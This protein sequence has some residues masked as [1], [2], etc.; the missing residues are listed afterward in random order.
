MNVC[1]GHLQAL[2]KK[3][4]DKI[5]GPWGLGAM[6]GMTLFKG[7]MEKSKQF[8]FKLFENG[9]LS[10]MAGSNP[11]RVRFLVPVGAVTLADIDKAC[12]IIEKTLLE[13]K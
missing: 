10:F 6:I 13:F 3:Y 2:H 12:E 9:V 4:P 11:T 5:E 8:T 7:D 1:T